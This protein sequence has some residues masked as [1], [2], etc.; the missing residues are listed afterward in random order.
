MKL[1]GTRHT[2]TG[3]VFD[4]RG[5]PIYDDVAKVE[6]RITGDLRSMSSDMHKRM[7]TK[8]LRADIESGKV[9]KN[10]FTEKQLRQ[11]D[12]KL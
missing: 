1:A 9:D 5:F 7:A 8:Q 3:I 6:T 10:L 11:I 2:E 4:Q 12:L